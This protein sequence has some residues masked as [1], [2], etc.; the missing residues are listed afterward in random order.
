MVSV[1]ILTEK[2]A[3]AAKLGAR[4]ACQCNPCT[5]KNCSC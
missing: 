2:Q 1:S 4:K 5:C 3:Q